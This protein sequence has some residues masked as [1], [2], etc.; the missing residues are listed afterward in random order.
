MCIDPVISQI[1]QSDPKEYTWLSPSV[2]TVLIFS[3]ADLIA[4]YIPDYMMVQ[5]MC[6]DPMI[7]QIGQ[8]DLYL[9]QQYTWLCPSV[10]TA[11]AVSLADLIIAYISKFSPCVF[12]ML[13][14]SLAELTS[15]SM[16]VLS[17]YPLPCLRWGIANSSSLLTMGTIH[18]IVWPF[19]L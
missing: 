18:W 19:S 16:Y 17:W 14:F 3:L 7:G 13:K 15:T 2:Y 12:I 6:I 4:V 10:F 11:L 8:S 5:P 9:H 1:G